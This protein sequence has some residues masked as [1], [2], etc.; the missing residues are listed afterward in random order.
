LTIG[1]ARRFATYKRGNLLLRDAPR[2]L[3]MLLNKDRPIQ[4][5]IAGKAH[6]AD[7]GGKDLIR[8]INNFARENKV[9]H[10]I[11]FVENYDISVARYLVQGCDV[12]LNTPRRGMEASGTSG[13]KAALNGV[14]NCSILD[15]WWD[16]AYQS[17]IGWAIGRGETYAN[18]DTQDDVE[19]H[20]LHDLLEQRILPLF[21][22][23]DENGIPR[24]WIA[25]MK[26]CISVLAPMFNTNRMVQEYAD[27]LYLPALRRT[28]K[29][30]ADNLA[31]SIALCH[32]KYR[33][34]AE[35]GK[36]RIEDVQA[37]TD[38]PLGVR[39]RL[40]V[41]AVVQLGGL[42]PEEL[43]VQLYY[44]ELDNDGRIINGKGEDLKHEQDLGGGRH[45]FAGSFSTSTSGR[46][47]FA[48]RIGPGGELFESMYEPGMICWDSM[49]QPAP[50][51]ATN[52]A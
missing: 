17:D 22:D 52:A 30:N 48:L 42:R 51:A 39:D 45:R 15:G 41:S 10:R 2:L 32:Q 19:S 24:A 14:L 5:I 43:R 20:A 9:A 31:K 25:R 47:G 7:G 35:W 40:E 6:P 16:E 37:N 23:R 21:Y 49:P 50:Q 26:R 3:R 44:G 1:F 28:R 18:I 11:I 27:E 46:H 12:W 4:F 13:M 38:K 29:F 8:Q 36:L 33:L 34:R